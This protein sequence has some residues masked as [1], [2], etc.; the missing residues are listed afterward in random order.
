MD[1]DARQS[2]AYPDR[3]DFFETTRLLRTGNRDP[4]FQR[5]PD[6]FWR[7]AQVEDGPVT[8]RVTVQEGREIEAMAWGPGAETALRSVPEWLGLH[9]PPWDL[10][11]HP[12]TDRLFRDHPGLRLTNTG[13][14]FEALLVSVLQQK[15]TWNE[16]AY[17]W[18]RLLEEFG[19]PAPGPRNDMRVVPTPRALREARPS[20]FI[21]LGVGRQ[22]AQTLRELGFWARKLQEAAGL[23]TADAQRLLQSAP[24]IG[25]WTAAV[26]LGHRLGRPE[27]LVFG[28]FHLP[29]TVSWALAREPR[30]TD[31]RM[32]ELLQPFDGHAFRVVRLI[33]ACRIEAPKF[34]PR[35]RL[36]FGRR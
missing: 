8:V 25:P 1:E 5:E 4:S 34:G 30:G 19:E 27:P 24:G 11:P 12:V 33:F 7:T 36:R 10:P 14:V 32:A 35:H 13:D 17:S 9:E 20:Q 28:D 6:G 16:A 15:V 2:W 23:P 31:E 22:Q 21:E 3:Y 29:H 26:V 18:R